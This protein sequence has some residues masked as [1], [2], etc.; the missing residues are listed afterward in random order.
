MPARWSRPGKQSPWESRSGSETWW[1]SCTWCSNSY[2]TEQNHMWLVSE[3]QILFTMWFC[4]VAV[5]LPEGLISCG[6][7]I[8]SDTLTAQLLSRGSIPG[9]NNSLLSDPDCFIPSLFSLH[10]IALQTDNNNMDNAKP[11]VCENTVIWSICFFLL[12]SSAIIFKCI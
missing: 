9:S 6:R 10:L 5:H 4:R 8:F 12:Q 3:P 7:M 1:P 2:G 11:V